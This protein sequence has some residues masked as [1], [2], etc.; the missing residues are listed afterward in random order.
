MRSLTSR[1]L[2]MSAAIGAA[3]ATS[4]ARW[5]PGQA[6]RAPSAQAVRLGQRPGVEPAPRLRAE[7]VVQAGDELV[8][9]AAGVVVGGVQRRL[10][11]T[12]TRSAKRRM[13]VD[14][15]SVCSPT[16][17][18]TVLPPRA[19]HG[20][21]VHR[22]RVAALAVGHARVVE[23]P[24]RLLAEVAE[25]ER[26][27]RRLARRA[28]VAAAMRVHGAESAP[29]AA[30][31]TAMRAP[32]AGD[33]VARP[34]VIVLTTV[35]SL[36]AAS[37][38]V[39]RMRAFTGRRTRRSCA[40]GVRVS[41][42]RNVISRLAPGCCFFRRASTTVTA[43][44]TASPGRLSLLQR[45]A[46]EDDGDARG[47]V[48]LD[49]HVES[50]REQGGAPDGRRTLTVTPGRVVSRIGGGGA[51]AAGAASP[52]AAAGRRRRVGQA[53]RAAGRRRGRPGRPP[54]GTRNGPM[55]S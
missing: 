54:A 8:R 53:R 41:F 39:T 6:A 24:A 18:G 34:I 13:S 28:C 2:A 14:S 7:D 31:R 4:S 22:G 47:L 21:P 50:A 33:Q 11:R 10:R 48:D 38:A 23:R 3:R 9:L 43:R 46:V 51:G 44:A 37:R 19:H 30:R 16:R 32:A 35:R 26:D 49:A 17:S 55:I 20:E 5:R 29:S 40:R 45:L 25:R 12:R 15:R 36:P 27:Q 1:R 52:P 42:S